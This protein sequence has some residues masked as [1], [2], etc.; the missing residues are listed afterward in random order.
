M[1]SYENERNDV[2]FSRSEGITN[3]KD[4]QN[5]LDESFVLLIFV[6][7]CLIISFYLINLLL[8]KY[9]FFKNIKSEYLNEFY[10]NYKVIIFI[11]FTVLVLTV[12]WNNFSHSIYQK[13][14]VSNYN[15]FIITAFVKWSYLIGFPFI[16]AVL[17]YFEFQSKN[18]HIYKAITTVIIL[19]F[20]LYTSLL[21][22]GM[23]F[24]MLSIIIGIALISYKK[25]N[26]FKILIFTTVFGSVVS[27]F[28]IFISEDLRNKIYFVGNL[29]S[30]PNY[31]NFPT[32]KNTI[33][34]NNV[35]LISN[36]SLSNQ[37]DKLD[38]FEVSKNHNFKS[39]INQ[40][41][42]VTLNRWVGI[43]PIILMNKNK[44]KLN[45][46][47]L[48]EAFSEKKDESFSFYE[49]TFIKE[50]SLREFPKNTF[51]VIL[52]GIIA[53]LYYPGSYLFLLVGIFIL[54]FC[55]ILLE[56]IVKIISDGNLILVS[57]ISN[58][59]I[60]RFIHF[61]YVPKD[62]YLLFGSLFFTLLIYFT[63]SKYL[64]KKN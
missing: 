22:R 38:N 34:S 62:S 43:E 7:F 15:F 53:F 23:P 60:Y 2:V 13:G 3:Y 24:E 55:L 20:T 42:Y 1:I 47:L 57:I 63:I 36:V 27:I 9:F 29:E 41:M 28:S 11:F 52:P 37:E 32:R 35:L 39:R 10:E 30:K 44:H 46:D 25:P 51:G 56:K 26:S 6:F 33:I 8:K 49:R 14:I 5:V 21:S 58:I 45:F 16:F 12:S 31:E 61:G 17:L 59:V 40:I 64:K 48:K 19:S 54:V 18:P 50:T 4:F